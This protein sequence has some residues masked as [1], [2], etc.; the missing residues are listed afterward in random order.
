MKR[1]S[2][3]QSLETCLKRSKSMT[4]KRHSEET[5]K[6]ISNSLKRYWEQIPNEE[7]NKSLIESLNEE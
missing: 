1:T 6:K 7:E 2:R 4:G 3:R 5:K